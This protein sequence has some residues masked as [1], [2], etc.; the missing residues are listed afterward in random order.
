MRAKTVKGLPVSF[1][2]IAFWLGCTERTASR[3]YTLLDNAIDDMRAA[4][5]TNRT[6][7]N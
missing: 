3:R 5:C 7:T 1:C 6:P 4:G 2:K